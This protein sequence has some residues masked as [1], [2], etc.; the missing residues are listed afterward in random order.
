MKNVTAL[1]I[2][3]ETISEL[4]YILKPYDIIVSIYKYTINCKL[5]GTKCKDFFLQSS[6][7][8]YI[9][10][11]IYICVVEYFDQFLFFF[12]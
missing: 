4:T 2:M 5:L 12:K 8:C 9:F 3:A 10:T 6:F 1:E 7:D 11:Y